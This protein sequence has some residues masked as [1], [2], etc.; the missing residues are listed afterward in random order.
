MRALSDV[1]FDVLAG[2]VTALLGENGAGKSTL[3]KILAGLQPPS[4]GTVTVFGE[5]GDLLRPQHHAVT[6]TVSRSFPSELS[7]LPGGSG[8]RERPERYGTGKTASGSPPAAG[9]RNAPPRFW[10]AWDLAL[11]PATPVGSLDLAHRAA[12]RGGLGP[13]CPAAAGS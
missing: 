1:S 13:A 10:P 7:R 2:E 3:L 11:D 12:R 5:Q 6:G 9:W 4:E 8:R